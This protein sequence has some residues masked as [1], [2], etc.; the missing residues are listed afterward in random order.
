MFQTRGVLFFLKHINWVGR[1]Y[2][3]CFVAAQN[4]KKFFIEFKPF[5]TSC[6]RICFVNKNCFSEEMFQFYINVSCLRSVQFR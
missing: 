1:K 5:K 4:F 6:E 3:R 2:I